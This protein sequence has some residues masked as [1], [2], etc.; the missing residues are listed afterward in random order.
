MSN[1]KRKFFNGW[2]W[3]ARAMPQL[4]VF[5]LLLTA[6]GCSK[7]FGEARPASYSMPPIML[8]PL[9]IP[10][11]LPAN[12]SFPSAERLTDDQWLGLEAMRWTFVP[13]KMERQVFRL[14]NEV[15]RE[16]H[17]PLLQWN[18][19]LSQAARAHSE[20]MA[21]LNYFSHRSPTPANATAEDRLAQVGLDY[22][23][24]AENIAKEPLARLYWSD[25]RVTRYT[26]GELAQNTLRHWFESIGHRRNLLRPDVSESGV[27]TAIRKDGR[28]AYLYVTQTFRKP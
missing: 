22:Q 17:L 13:E 18:A 25:G 1:C 8:G 11:S 9:P 19:K 28:V 21:R 7:A 24:S 23:V 5:S 3:L 6:S 2:G 15:R 10:T 12:A 20:E 26:W 4:L 16:N 14:S 27:G